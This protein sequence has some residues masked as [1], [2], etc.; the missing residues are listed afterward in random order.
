M[1]VMARGRDRID[2]RLPVHAST[3]QHRELGGFARYCILRVERELGEREAWIVDIA[4]ALGGY[5]SRVAMCDR[6]AMLE[7]Q[8]TGHDGPLAIWEAMCRLEQRMREQRR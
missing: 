7:E 3:R 1:A 6:G 8:G 4:P 5:T 2:V